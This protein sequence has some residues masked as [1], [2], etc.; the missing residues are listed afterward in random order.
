M[1]SRSLRAK[2][3]NPPFQQAGLLR[4]MQEWIEAAEAEPAD[5]EELE[6]EYYAALH[7]DLRDRPGSKI[8]RALLNWRQPGQSREPAARPIGRSGI[9]TRNRRP[10]RCPRT[11]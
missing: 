8:G 2:R 10:A 3:S 9:C 7:A 1:L 6:V 5:I 11:G 4:Q